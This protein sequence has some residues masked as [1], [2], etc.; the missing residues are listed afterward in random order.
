MRERRVCSPITF[1]PLAAF[2]PELEP[3]TRSLRNDIIRVTH[4]D[5]IVVIK[6]GTIEAIRT[7]S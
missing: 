3:L 7:K 1:L 6:E 2:L 5:R 4:A